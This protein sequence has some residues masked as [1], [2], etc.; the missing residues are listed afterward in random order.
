MNYFLG[1]DGGQSH[2]TALIADGNGR[3]L[4]WGG[5]GA[6]N[7]TR[8]PGGRERLI[9][10][11]TKSVDEALERAGLK[12][13]PKGGTAKFKFASAHLAMCGEPEYKIDIVNELL[14]AEHLVVGHDAP[15]GLAGALAGG[16]GVIVLAGTGSVACGETADGRLV[17]VG[18]HGYM[19]GDEGSAYGITCDAMRVALALQDR[20]TPGALNDELLAHFKFSSLKEIAEEF[21]AGLLSRDRL[22]SFAAK[23][24]KVAGRKDPAAIEVLD[25][26]AEALAALAIACVNRLGGR[27][28]KVSYGGGVFKS[29]LILNAFA[30]MVLD[31][32]PDAEIVAPRFKSEVG[33]LLLAYRQAG[34]KITPKLLANITETQT[35]K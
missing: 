9:T 32:L 6:C 33:A 24:S 2:T 8:E 7:H 19:F 27:A 10:A 28:L 21:Y 17:R 12:T 34:K 1:I 35:T 18:G 3:I 13:A 31:E 11:V 26:A 15:G 29:R 20:G 14:R 5:A 22:A 23:V 16:E 30:E 4:G 25:V